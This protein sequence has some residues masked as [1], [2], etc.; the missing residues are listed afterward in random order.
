MELY[1]IPT[2]AATGRLSTALV[3]ACGDGSADTFPGKRSR[4]APAS[5]TM[6]TEK[7]RVATH[8]ESILAAG[9]FE[10]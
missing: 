9:K 5:L 6:A 7:A 3:V 8:V 1:R 2:P 10:T 4:Y